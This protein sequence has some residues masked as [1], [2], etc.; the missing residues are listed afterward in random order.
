LDLDTKTIRP[1]MRLLIDS[2][3]VRT[4][5]QRRGMRYEAV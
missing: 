1:A 4:D 3:K 5:G 2:G